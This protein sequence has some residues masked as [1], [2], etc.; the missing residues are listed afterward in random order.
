MTNSLAGLFA[1]TISDILVHCHWYFR[2]TR[3][4][5]EYPTQLDRLLVEGRF[6]RGKRPG[7]RATY[8]LVTSQQTTVK[9]DRTYHVLIP[10]PDLRSP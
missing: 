7:V 9:H 10:P 4:I 3:Q 1:V 5:L 2:V 8:I 6:K